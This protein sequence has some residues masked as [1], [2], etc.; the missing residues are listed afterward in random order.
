VK[1]PEQKLTLAIRDYLN[2]TNQCAPKDT[3]LEFL[4]KVRTDGEKVELAYVVLVEVPAPKITA[5]SVE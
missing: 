4:L 1:T 5:A 2:D 3:W